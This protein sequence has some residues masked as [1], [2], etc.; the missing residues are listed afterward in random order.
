MSREATYRRWLGLGFIAL[1]Q[2]MIALDA[3]IVSIALPSAQAALRVGDSDRQWFVT[4]YTLAFGALLLPGGRL[5]DQLGRKRAFI[6]GLTGF[7]LASLLGGAA[8]GFPVLVAA[9]AL[10]GAF[11]ALLAPT[12]LSILAVTFSDP[13]ERATAFAVWG[14]IAGSGAAIGMLL[15]GALTQYLNWRW[16]LLVNLPVAAVSAAGATAIL[17]DEPGH[18]RGAL[19][20]LALTAARVVKDRSRAGTY[21][22]VGLAI[23]G[24]LGAYLLL[25][26]HL[27]A[28][29]RFTPLQAGLGFL[30]ITIASQAGSWLVA[31]RLATRVAP[32]LQMAIGALV[33]GA[34]LAWLSQAAAAAGYALGVLPAELLLGLGISTAMVPA[35]STAT[36]GVDRRDAGVAAALVNSA[37]QIGG[38]AGA[39][40][41]N[42]LATMLG[43]QAAAGCGALLLVLAA[44]AAATLV[45]SA[46]PQ[47]AGARAVA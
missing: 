24:M 13:K 42:A 1:A 8:P 37:Q 18:R 28:G 40:L 35:F 36:L 44:I 2:L 38:S 17:K 14:S 22:T 27:Q 25:T 26:Y 11:A 4:A 43:I 33:A 30:P 41:L 32:Q 47:P 21:A 46:R 3:T 23:A 7:A 31:R 5:A 12:A 29:L 20:D 10:Q 19:V 45:R 34:G 9:R 6:A 39:A 15:G 16:C